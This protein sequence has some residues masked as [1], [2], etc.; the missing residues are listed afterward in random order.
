MKPK[1]AVALRYQQQDDMAPRVVAKGSGAVA[2]AILHR[3]REANVA[4]REDDALVD[5]L[6]ALEV[7][8][9]IPEALYAAVAEV[10]AIVYRQREG[11]A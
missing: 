7:E 8:A 1:R 10:L 3:A 5:A 6:M 4:V 2:E 9:V 11:E